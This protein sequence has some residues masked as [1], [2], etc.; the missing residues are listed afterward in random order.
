MA[1][2]IQVQLQK[3]IKA[4]EDLTAKVAE[5]TATKTT[6]EADLL[7]KVEALNGNIAQL[8]ADVTEKNATI[9]ELQAKV[10]ALEATEKDLATRA[11]AEAA[12]IVASTGHSAPLNLS[13]EST[14]ETIFEK[15]KSEKNP[16]KRQAIMLANFD[17]FA[18]NPEKLK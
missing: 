8:T 6:A 15:Y 2:T 12:R 5:L 18:K 11:A 7:S 14:Q 10:A 1:E 13:A 17:L 16:A 4:N 9:T 3:A